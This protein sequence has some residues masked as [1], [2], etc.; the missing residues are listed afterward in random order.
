MTFFVS[1]VSLRPGTATDSIKYGYIVYITVKNSYYTN[2]LEALREGIERTIDRGATAFKIGELMDKHGS[3]DWLGSFVDQ[4]GPEFQVFVADFAS[5]LETI[6]NFYHYRRPE[7]TAYT[8]CLFVA[9]FLVTAFTDSQFAMKIFWLN[10][11]LVFFGCWPI[12][13]LHPRYRLLVSP[14]R[15][16]LWNVPNHAE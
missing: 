15:L 4:I 10:I 1:R 11:G 5:L 3:D 12:S 7:Q 2:S 9:L 14:F 6:Y 13:S 16:V 8:L